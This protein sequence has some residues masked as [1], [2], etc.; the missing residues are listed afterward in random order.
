[1]AVPAQTQQPAAPAPASNQSSTA[2]ALLE[3]LRKHLENELTV[4]RRLLAIAEQMG[5]KLMTGDAVAV[6]ALVAQEQEPARE[7]ARLAGIRERLAKALAI[8]YQLTGEVTLS[9]ILPRAPDGLR[10]EL[11]RLR[12]EV[13]AVCQRLG[14]QAERNLV[15]ARQGLA[16]I[17]D[18]ISSSLGEHAPAIAYDRRGMIGNPI[19][20]RGA[21]L[22]IR[23]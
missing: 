17:R 16:L 9:R 18:V 8:V 23:G 5:P 3:Q 11:E 21:V 2:Q 7:A 1:M 22:N 10:A 6:S 15:V 20:P 12:R 14:R 13:A 19:P 4:Q